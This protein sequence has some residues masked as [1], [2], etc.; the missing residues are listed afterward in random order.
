MRAIIL[1]AGQGTRIRA[2]HGER[3]KCLIRRDQS[4]WTILDQQIGALFEAGVAN[5][6]IVVGYQRDQI[7]SHV[8]RYYRQCLDRFRF[9]ENPQFAATNNI[10]SLWMARAWLKGSSSV[11]LNADVAFDGGILPP[12]LASTAPVT[13]IVDPMWRDETMKVI[14]RNGRVV[15]M[16]KQISLDAFDATYIGIT[17]VYAATH[18]RLF[19]RIE[20]ADSRRRES[21]VF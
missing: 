1:A 3:P 19:N 10:H 11:V 13:M 18:G 2:A 6:G 14:I 5:I 8:T 12:A 21:G 4:G 20:V 15:R 7:V 17:V 16:S 9:I